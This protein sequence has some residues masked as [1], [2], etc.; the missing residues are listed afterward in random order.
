LLDVSFS[1]TD[2]PESLL[3]LPVCRVFAL[4]SE[5]ELAA[6]AIVLGG[7]Q[8][9]SDATEN[10]DGLGGLE[11][12]D[13]PRVDVLIMLSLFFDDIESLALA[14]LGTPSHLEF[15]FGTVGGSF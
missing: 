9:P 12:L 15:T 6:D 10:M 4:K 3:S 7:L 2:G 13:V 14:G 5:T 11:T 8:E 1:I